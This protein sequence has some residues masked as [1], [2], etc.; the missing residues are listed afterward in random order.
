MLR[1]HWLIL[2]RE[3]LGFAGLLA[4]G[5][6]I[7]YVAG[8]YFGAYYEVANFLLAV[9]ILIIWQI[10]FTS[11]VDY[12]LDTWI[13]TDHR[14]IDIHQTGFFRRDISE[15]RY[16]K[17]QDVSVKING[18][19]PTIANYGDL[20]IQTAGAVQEFHF[21]QI[22]DPNRVRDRILRLH[23]EF[24]RIHVNDIEVHDTLG[25]GGV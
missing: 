22:P 16:S 9:Y 11:L 13:V 23:D 17:I 25:E 4:I 12:Y 18:F 6:A 19:I 10:F 21:Q 1:R 15:L 24:I 8:R 3:F 20:I 2:S 14:I 7:Y 5:L